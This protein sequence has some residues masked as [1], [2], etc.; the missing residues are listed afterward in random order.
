MDPISKEPLLAPSA[1]PAGLPSAPPL[2][3]AIPE[4][5]V[6]S[7]SDA[8]PAPAATVVA[9]E[10]PYFYTPAELATLDASPLHEYFDGGE[11]AAAARTPLDAAAPLAVAR[12]GAA[13]AALA[14]PLL[15]TAAGVPVVAVARSPSRAVTLRDGR[16]GVKS[17]D[18]LLQTSPEEI[19]LFMQTH[20]TRPFLAAHVVGYHHETRTR[21]VT[22]V[23]N[24]GRERR[25]TETYSERV[26]DFDY[27]V[28]V[29]DWIYPVGYIHADGP[30]SV[31]EVVEAYVRDAN[32]LKTL[33]MTKEIDGFDFD[34]L[35][36]AIHGHIRALGWCREL[37]VDFPTANA[38]VRVFNENRLSRLWENS[39]GF[40]LLHATLLP[41]LALRCY[42]GDCNRCLC[43]A[44]GSSRNAAIKSSFRIPYHP[45]Q[46]FDAIAPQLWCPGWSGA[47]LA[48]D[49]IA[50]AL[51]YGVASRGRRRRRRGRRW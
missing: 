1:P 24:K 5:E 31:P 33:Q 18:A 11:A 6:V 26:D 47:A 48:M 51:E 50:S 8:M 36:N 20:N 25:E 35:R 10:S 41:C 14:A 43:R 7:V 34:A 46:V 39:C 16:S 44:A 38:S 29:S 49:T 30:N 12:G 37:S 23:D 2:E 9:V 3:D 32:L 45:R 22:R 27:K 21:R 4:A 15:T 17:G 19:M 13:G 42:R 40:C 28:D